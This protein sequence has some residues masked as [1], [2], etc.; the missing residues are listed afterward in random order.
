MEA[1]IKDYITK[2]NIMLIKGY[3]SEINCKHK[4]QEY[5]GG[6]KCLKCNYY[7]GL[8]DTLN[9]LIKKLLTTKKK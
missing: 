9:N 4:W 8:N 2:Q 3:L 5:G 1:K 7:T 6:Y